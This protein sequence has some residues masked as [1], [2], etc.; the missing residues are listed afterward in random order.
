MEAL[1]DDELRDVALRRMQGE[2]VEAIA[3]QLGYAPRSIKRKLQLI[4]GI[5]E[6]ELSK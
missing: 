3:E 5:W 1:A 4:R 2:S 6:K